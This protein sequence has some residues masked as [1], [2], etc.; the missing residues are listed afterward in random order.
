ME[1]NKQARKILTSW[2]NDK[3][4]P[5]DTHTLSLV[6]FLWQILQ[7]FHCHRGNR[8]EGI[9]HN[10]YRWFHWFHDNA[11]CGGDNV[12]LHWHEAIDHQSIQ[13]YTIMSLSWYDLQGIYMYANYNNKSVV[14]SLAMCIRN[15]G[16]FE[17]P[18]LGYK[19]WLNLHNFD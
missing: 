2:Q 17:T 18:G 6:F 19:T 13:K 11:R 9:F 5:Y 10:L 1:W 14:Y 7:Y 12:V 8:I 16:I 3:W 4:Y 15:E